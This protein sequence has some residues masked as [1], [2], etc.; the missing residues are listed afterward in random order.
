M[1]SFPLQGLAG[2]PAL[3]MASVVG[4]ATFGA[5]LQLSLQDSL[6]LEQVYSMHVSQGQDCN[7]NAFDPT[8]V[9]FEL[10]QTP[11]SADVLI[12]EVLFNPRSGGV[13][14]VEVYNR[15][16]KFLNLRNWRL[17]DEEAGVLRQ[18]IVGAENQVLRPGQFLVLTTSP[19]TLRAHYPR[20]VSERF[21][22]S[23]MPSMPDDEGEVVLL[24]SLFQ[25]LDRLDYDEDM[26]S[27]LL[28]DE[29]GVSLER[30]SLEQGTNHRSNWMSAAAQAGYATPGYANTQNAELFTGLAPVLAAPRVF[31]PGSGLMPQFTQVSYTLQQGGAYLT[32][33]VVDRSGRRVKT[34]L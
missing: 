28:E 9:N 2:S 17:A 7:G 12:N 4:A 26:H 32:L 19:T 6:V 10:C 1:S 33:L 29:N 27:A 8:P 25:L 30:L 20:G 14:F 11:D 5:R 31:V 22:T 13:D 24:D 34:L 23:A 15:S 21:Y 18:S 3:P 16:S